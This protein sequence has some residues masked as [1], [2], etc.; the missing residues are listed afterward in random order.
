MLSLKNANPEIVASK[1]PKDLCLPDGSID[2][3]SLRSFEDRVKASGLEEAQLE[4]NFEAFEPS[5]ENKAIFD[6]M[7]AWTFTKYGLMLGGDVGRG[8]THLCVALCLKMMEQ[9]YNAYFAPVG[10]TLNELMTMKSHELPEERN[11][12]SELMQKLTT[13]EILILDD[14]G[15][16]TL[17]EAKMTAL[18]DIIN[19]RTNNKEKRKTFFTTN[20]RWKLIEE[21]YDQRITS[22]IRE[23]CDFRLLDG[24][25]MREEMRKERMR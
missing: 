21:K 20:L 23:I 24:I 15:T 10:K 11:K 7:K 19:Q 4:K 12:Y 8:K 17:T 6:E 5:P 16:E 3:R 2:P 1:N 25:D 14:L 22:R 9:R 18:F 13:V